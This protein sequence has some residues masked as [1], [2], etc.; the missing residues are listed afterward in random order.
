MADDTLTK[1]RLVDEL[2]GSVGITKKEAG[3]L[4]DTVFDL[5]REALDAG[6]KV[7]ISGFGNWV[8]RDKS[9]R[10][11]RNPQTNEPIVIA[12]RRVLSFKPSQVLRA[13]LNEEG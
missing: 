7:K 10:K 5:M 4:V 6:D 13:A 12:R 3:D 8:V 2:N 9:A 11:G 1:A